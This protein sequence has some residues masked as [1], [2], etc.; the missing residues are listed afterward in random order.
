[1]SFFSHYV[2]SFSFH[3]TLNSELPSQHPSIFNFLDSIRKTVVGNG[4]SVVAQ[5]QAGRFPR[6]KADRA[7][8]ELLRKATTVEEDY[9]AGNIS[10]KEVLL[11][12]AA[13]FDDD[14]LVLVMSNYA[15]DVEAQV[16]EEPEIDPCEG[17]L[18]INNSFIDLSIELRL[19]NV[20][21]PFIS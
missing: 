5:I 10:A 18:N 13:H 19:Q 4:I 2:R 7:R 9:L 1:M 12:V 3:K 14:Q 6:R 11:A 15:T 16:D 20:A 8:D 21:L 17:N